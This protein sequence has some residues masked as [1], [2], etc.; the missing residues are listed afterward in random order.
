MRGYLG[1]GRLAV[2]ALRGQITRASASLPL[3]EQPLLGG[4]ESLRGYRA[5]VRA[6]DSM[7]ALS[8]ELRV[9][10][11]S[12]VRYARMGARTFVDLG[13]TWDANERLTKQRF[14]RGAGAGVYFGVAMFN[15]GVDLA[16]PEH[17]RPRLHV[18]L[19]T[20]F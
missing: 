7:T 3:S 16:W 15:A 6:G 17:G 11:A 10:V 5:G 4:T 12:P 20:T 8:A 14:D 18:S 19:G 1:L 13:T 9:P 2:L